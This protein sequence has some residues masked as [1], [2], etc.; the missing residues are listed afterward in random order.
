MKISEIF[1]SIQCEI[2]IGKPCIFIRFS[3]CNLI[4]EGRGCEFCDSLYSEQGNEMT[5]EDVMLV[6]RKYDC[7]NVVITGGES[8]MQ[9]DELTKLMH[10]LV[11]K[12]YNIDI[13]TNGTIF[14]EDIMWNCDNIN[15]SPKRQAVNYEVLK[16]LID[17]PTRFKF[18]FESKDD[19]WWEEVIDKVGIEKKNVWIMPCGKMKVEQEKKMIEV[20][21]YCKLKGFNFSPRLHVLVYGEKRGV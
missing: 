17:Y 14:G 1:H 19:L 11:D 10:L 13:E 4:K 9:L 20:I 21:E 3:G 8:L 6:V 7:N 18:V 2:N 12:K 16:K 5:V 15:C